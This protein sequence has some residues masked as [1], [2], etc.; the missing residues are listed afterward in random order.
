MGFNPP[1]P[2][3]DSNW[4]I[5]VAVL[6]SLAFQVVLIFAGPL[7][8]RSSSSLVRFVIWS[9]YLLAD[10]VADLALGLLLNNMGNIGGNG[11]ST[12]D[13]AVTS[14]AAALKHVLHGGTDTSGSFGG[15]GGGGGSPIIFAFWAPFLLLHLGGPDTITAYSLADNELWLRHLIGLLFELSAAAVV[16]LCSLQQGNPMVVP[17]VLMFIAGIIKYGERT[18]SLYTGST[19]RFTA[20]ILGKPQYVQRIDRLMQAYNSSLRAGFKVKM[21]TFG[22]SGTLHDMYRRE[23]V[24]LSQSG[25]YDGADEVRAHKLMAHFRPLFG[26]GV[27]STKNRRVSE[28]FFL[29][30]GGRDPM[31]A[32]HILELELNYTYE[33]FYT[34]MPVLSTRAGYVLRFVGCGCVVS[35]LVIFRAHDKAGL[36]PV[37][38]AVT[39][40]LLIAAVALEAAALVMLLFSDWTL[41][42]I[43]QYSRF[44]WLSWLIS[45]VKKAKL[46]RRRRRTWSGTVWQMNLID[47]SI[48]MRMPD[49]RRG[50]VLTP[51]VNAATSFTDMI[52][53][54]RHGRP[55]GYTKKDQEE[56]HQE[57]LT[58]IFDRIRDTVTKATTPEEWKMAC[59]DRVKRVL[60]GTAGFE[61][62]TILWSVSRCDFD[63]SLLLWHIATD[64]CLNAAYDRAT[65][66]L[67]ETRKMMT[68]SRVLSDYMLYLLVSKPEMMSATM[69]I[70]AQA[71]LLYRNTCAEARLLFQSSASQYGSC[72]VIDNHQSA[73]S[74]VQDNVERTKAII[75]NACMLAKELMGSI[76]GPEAM[77][78][79]VAHVWWEMLMF[80]AS[81]TP[82]R[83]HLR[84]LSN[85]GE[86]ITFVWL[87]MAHMGMS[88]SLFEVHETSL[89]KLII[90]DQ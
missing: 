53:R 85:G 2:Q 47:Q 76:A 72:D 80:N 52:R 24:L 89:D 48:P 84:Q 78:R 30:H 68:V 27:I 34:K 56:Y 18:Y 67:Q 40:A 50:L 63:E 13:M 90:I 77:W 10:W 23:G 32:F 71:Q 74:F 79:V 69:G 41:V 37:D 28:A 43:H 12:G 3:R 26:N 36:L 81:R 4:E 29:E 44:K 60:L 5:R 62:T 21:I 49:G 25:Q 15:T 38:A 83:E 64:L 88:S 45:S 58:F 51:L 46:C 9:C 65:E 35:S 42:F 7:R 73:C 19:D 87:L 55:L 14:T 82:A 6:L 39:Y 22:E 11:G 66:P 8:K 33:T 1:V 57:L 31:E 54:H 86:L 70:G 17:T 59:L 61:S 16:F 20:S 75:F